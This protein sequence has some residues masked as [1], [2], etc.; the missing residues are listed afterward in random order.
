MSNERTADEL[1]HAQDVR[2][3]FSRISPKYDFLNHFLSVNIDKR[4]RRLVTKKLEN[5]LER[6]KCARFGCRLRH[7]RFGIRIAKSGKS[8]S[9]RHGFLPSDAGNCQ[10]KKRAGKSNDSVSRSRRNE[11]VVCRQNF[12]RGNNRFR[13]AKFFQLAR[14][15]KRTCTAF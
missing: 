10:R 8:K 7:G 1:K 15:F 14:R 6:P 5:I 4:W 3:M 9:Y 11:F 12:R 13:F 2:E